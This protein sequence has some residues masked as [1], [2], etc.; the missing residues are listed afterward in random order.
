MI[1]ILLGL[2]ISITLVWIFSNTS[3][4][5]LSPLTT[6]DQFLTS[7]P[8]IRVSL[9]SRDLILIQPSSSIFVYALGFVMIL[10]GVFFFASRNAD[11][12]RS[13]WGI[14][15]I[16]WG[17]GAIMA[18]TS[19]QAFGYELKCAGKEYCQITSNFELI[20][21][22]LTAYSI[23]FL[24]AATGFTSLG[25]VGRKWIIRFAVLDSIFYS[26]FLLIGAIIPIKF[27]ISYEGFMSFIGV[28]FVIMFLLNIRHYIKFKDSLN[29]GLIIIWVGFL[30]VN[31]GYF[32]FLFGQFGL[33]LYESSGIWFNENDALHVLLIVWAIMIL[34]ILRKKLM[35]TTS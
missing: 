8:H 20:Y 9:F 11:K 3:Q 5:L 29:R 10:I 27:L 18:G 33:K 23:N 7:M 14:G 32:A 21:M 25:K 16:L 17:I 4:F 26:I 6:P 31:L 28:N 34:W 22:L 35:D 2:V 30:I 24:V 15:L 12:S 1:L 13:Y 19:Y